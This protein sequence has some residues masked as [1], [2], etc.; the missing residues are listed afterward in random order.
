MP[1]T[2]ETSARV[3]EYVDVLIVGAGISGIAAGYYVQ[4]RCPHLSWTI[5]ESRAAIGGT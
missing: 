2:S 4:K 3:A 1:G 5:V